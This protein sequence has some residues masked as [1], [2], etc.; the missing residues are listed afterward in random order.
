M[1]ELVGRCL[2]EDQY[3]LINSHSC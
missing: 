2:S 1:F 3:I